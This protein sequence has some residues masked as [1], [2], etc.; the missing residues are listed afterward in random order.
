MRN[1]RSY[2]PA[3]I[4]GALLAAGGGSVAAHHGW[5][6]TSPEPFTLTG[7]VTEIY[8]GNPHVTLEVQ[9][10]EGLWHVDLAPLI[11]TT[12]AGFTQ[13]SVSVGESVTLYGHRSTMPELAMK[14][15]RVVVNGITYDVYADRTAP[16]D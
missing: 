3:I 12:E 16:F 13:N 10:E 4:A 11:R 2:R 6:W 15:V 9:T 14:A 5:A 7:T 8:I 1:L